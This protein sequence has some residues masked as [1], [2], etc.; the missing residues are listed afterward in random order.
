MDGFLRRR[1][2]VERSLRPRNAPAPALCD[3]MDAGLLHKKSHRD[4]AAR[5][6]APALS[7]GFARRRNSLSPAQ[8]LRSM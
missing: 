5:A 4:G 1:A 2:A 8:G 3:A 7:S 6:A